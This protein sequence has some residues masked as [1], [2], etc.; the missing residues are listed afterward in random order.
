MCRHVCALQHLRKPAK[1][2][3][4]VLDQLERRRRALAE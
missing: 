2:T 4:N 3:D 1:C